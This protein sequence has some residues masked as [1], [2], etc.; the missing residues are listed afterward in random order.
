MLK[1]R[2]QEL[3]KRFGVAVCPM[4]CELS[5]PLERAKLLETVRS[6]SRVDWLVNNAGYGRGIAFSADEYEEQRNLLRVHVEAVMELTHAV[7]PKMPPGGRIVTVSS[8]AGLVVSRRS[9]VYCAAK[10][11]ATSFSESLALEL[12]PR[13]IRVQALLPGFTQSEFHRYDSTAK[14]SR[15]PVRWMTAD[16]VVLA[17]L[18]AADRGRILCVPGVANRFLY[19]MAK[20]LPRTVIHRLTA[21]GLQRAATPGAIRSRARS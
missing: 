15:G 13:G 8:L 11:F 19:I 18:R 5:D 14:R 9:A 1:T 6:L 7:V 3:G 2:A 21:G 16:A 17:S 12:A 20:L 10:A 4:L